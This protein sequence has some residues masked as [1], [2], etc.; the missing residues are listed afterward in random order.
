MLLLFRIEVAKVQKKSLRTPKKQVFV[1]KESIN[2]ND[3]ETSELL[4]L[5]SFYH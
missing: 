3:I 4:H 2:G 5:A 1:Q